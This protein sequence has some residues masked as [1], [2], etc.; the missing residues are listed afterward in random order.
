VKI[1]WTQS[2][3]AALQ[4]CILSLLH[5][6][7][8]VSA[9]RFVCALVGV[10]CFLP[11]LAG[12]LVQF[13]TP[14]GDIDI[15]LYDN[16]KPQTVQ[17]F[18]RYSQDGLYDSEFAHR[19]IPAF[20]IQGGGYTVT[21]RGTTNYSVNPI[22]AYPPITNEFS[23]GARY[24]NVYG[25]LAM[26][27]VPGDTNSATSQWFLN[28]T[29]NSFLD[30][31]DSNNLFVVFGHVLRGTNIL[32]TFNH[33]QYWDYSGLQTSNIIYKGLGPGAFYDLPLMRPGLAT[34]TNLVYIDISFLSVQI[35]R[36]NG[37]RQISWNSITGKTN[38]VEYTTNFPAVWRTL[39]TTNGNGNRIA[40][41]DPTP[42]N[43]YR[44]YRVRVL[45]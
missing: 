34:D 33:F 14:L 21:N 27:K 35:A 19:L 24:S 38:L 4:D 40:V 9:R 11:A 13:R 7:I 42:T 5:Y 43:Q 2:F 30:A 28:L 1:Q 37:T 26:A 25:T 45:Y 23:K 36:T 15:E 41:T 22:P 18:K 12:T 44:F 8:R 3:Q 32:N 39:V 20:V 29:N 16:D 31:A 17:N 10:C 6:Y